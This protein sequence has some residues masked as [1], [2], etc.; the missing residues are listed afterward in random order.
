VIRHD[1]NLIDV[2]FAVC[3]ALDRVGIVAVLVGGSAANFYA[4][5]KYQSHDAD[6]VIT[7]ER[8]RGTA[9][10]VMMDLGFQREGQMYVH[11]ETPF[12]IEFPPGP[13]SVAGMLVSR[14]ETVRRGE[15]IL[16]V[17]S[18]TDC[19][20]DRLAA[21]Y[22]W[23]DAGSLYVALDVAR[24]GPIDLAS[25]RQWSASEGENERFE[26]FAQLLQG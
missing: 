17:V 6:F 3:T 26:R 20:R 23:N 10:K 9:A 12:T 8:Q 2:A 11:S 1:G 5:Q 21:F 13:L 16:Y 22:F 7:L 4:P 24:S 19:V 25:I 14:W 18:R 15:E